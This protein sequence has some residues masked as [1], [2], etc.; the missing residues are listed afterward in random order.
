MRSEKFLQL[1]RKFRRNTDEEIEKALGSVPDKDDKENNEKMESHQNFWDDRI[2]MWKEG[3]ETVR[4]DLKKANDLYAKNIHGVTDGQSEF[5]GYGNGKIYTYKQW[6]GHFRDELSDNDKQVKRFKRLK[7]LDRKI[8]KLQYIG[9]RRDK[10][11]ADIQLE[12]FNG[13]SIASDGSTRQHKISNQDVTD[14]FTP[15]YIYV[16]MNKFYSLTLNEQLHHGRY[17]SWDTL[18]EAREVLD[19]DTK[20]ESVEEQYSSV[21]FCPKKQIYKLYKVDK[22][23]FDMKDEE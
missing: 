18:K 10:K 22:S 12:E 4:K 16:V 23:G 11:T 5:T 13:C 21:A 17:V 8:T 9:Q 15:E 6:C 14:L 20:F 1:Y 3:V 2:R 19:E 7:E